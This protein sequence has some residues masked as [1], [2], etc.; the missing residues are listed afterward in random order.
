MNILGIS[1][2]QKQKFKNNEPQNKVYWVFL[3]KKRLNFFCYYQIANF[4]MDN[5][6][7]HLEVILISSSLDLERFLFF[8][9]KG[10][11]KG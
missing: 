6:T 8:L 10:K 2:P 4:T 1:K 5:C 7:H 11:S 3:T 9:G